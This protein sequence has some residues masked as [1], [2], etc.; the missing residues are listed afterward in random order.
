MDVVAAGT[1]AERIQ[2]YALRANAIFMDETAAE[3]VALNVN[4]GRNLAQ[5]P[6]WRRYAGIVETEMVSDNQRLAVEINVALQIV[7]SSALEE[8]T[9][10][11]LKALTDQAADTGG[12][13][14]TIIEQA[15]FERALSNVL[16]SAAEDAVKN[17]KKNYV[18][19][20]GNAAYDGHMD[21]IKDGTKNL[22]GQMIAGAAAGLSALAAYAAWHW[23]LPVLVYLG[24]Q[25]P[26]P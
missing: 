6:E 3:V 7:T 23:L 26:R 13:A 16:A 20:A 24:T 8:E 1:V 18:K 15:G 22:T 9:A 11:A 10:A 21:G 25:I 5:F 4:V 2:Q 12:E 14:A 19:D 17:H